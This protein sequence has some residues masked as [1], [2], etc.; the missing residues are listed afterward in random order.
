MP[1]SSEELFGAVSRAYERGRLHRAW[2]VAAVPAA[3]AAMALWRAAPWALSVA[4][5]TAAAALAVYARWRGRPL[6]AGLWPGLLLGAV[7]VLASGLAPAARAVWGLAS[8]SALCF[9][10]TLSGGLLFGA[11]AGWTSRTPAGLAVTLGLAAL[12]APLGCLTMT[13]GGSLGLLF[14]AAL[15]LLPALSLRAL[16]A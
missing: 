9:S 2:P 10:V 4:C 6:D 7:P 5:G 12:L 8:C 1:S 14:G 13:L 15:G 11:L 16:R 3:I